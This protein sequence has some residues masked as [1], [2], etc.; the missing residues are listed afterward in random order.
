[1]SSPHFDILLKEKQ[2]KVTP[3]R[4]AI[5]KEIHKAGH[6]SVDS[7]YE[8]IKQSYP[9]MSLATVYKN[10]T[11]MQEANIIEELQIPNQKQHY[12]LHK[13]PH[14]HL[15]CQKCGKIEDMHSNAL[16]QQLIAECK[17]ESHYTFKDFS[18]ALIGVC[19]ECES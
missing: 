8:N 11:S 14:I 1:M 16:L 18:I 7:I 19:P 9:S 5:L 12:E 17:E 6:I 2:L 15:I 3:Q 4:M 13:D 10:L